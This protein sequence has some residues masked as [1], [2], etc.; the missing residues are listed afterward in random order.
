MTSPAQPMG[1]FDLCGPLPGPGVT[2]LEASAGTGKTFTIAGL[3]TR[4]VAEDVVPLSQILVVTFTRMATGELRDRVRTGLATAELALERLMSSGEAP[5]EDDDVLALLAAD[6]ASVPDRRRRLADAL[7]DFDSATI[8]TTHGF[9]H[10]VLAALGVWGEVAP[11]ASLLEDPTDLV[12]EVVDDL[13]A[14]HMLISGDLPF[15]RR[16]AVGAGK[17]AVFNPGTALAPRADRSDNTTSG[18]RRRLAEGTRRE[19]SRRL[20]DANLLTYDDLLVRLEKA[21]SDP[22]RGATAC[23]RLR[24]RYRAV[25]VDEFQDTDLVQ[26]EIVRRAFASDSPGCVGGHGNGD[27]DGPPE[28]EGD[29]TATRLVLIG[30]PKQ[31]VYSFRGA[32]VH[33]YLA[34]ARAAPAG[35]RSTLDENWRSDAG[36]LKAYDA[37]LSP[38]HLGHPGIEYRP[39]RAAPAHRLP[40]LSGAPVAAPLRARLVSRSGR[41]LH[42]TRSGLVQKDAALKWVAEDLASDVVE[43]LSSGAELLRGGSGQATPEPGSALWPRPVGPQDIGVLV[44]TNRQA[45]VVQTALRAAGVPVVVAGAQSVLSTPAARDWATLLNALEQPA[46]R[47][48]AVA[49]GL[50]AFLGMTGDQLATADDREWEALHAKLH[51]WGALARRSGV[52]TMFAN[53]SVS[54]RLPERLL[55][56]ADGE[57]RLTDLTHIAELLHAE[58]MSGQLGLAA[59][60]AWLAR[61]TGE[62]SPE[63]G[64]EEQRSRRLDS[65]AAAVQVLTVHRAKGL[66]FPVVYCPYL[67][68]GAARDRFGQPVVFHD[69]SGDEERKLDVGGEKGDCT[70]QSHFAA[71]Q[72]EKR[73]EDL[74]HLYVALTRAK[75]Q[76]VLWWAPARSCQHSALGRLLLSKDAEGDVAANGRPGE[77]K[78]PE[79]AAAFERV[80]RRAPGLVSVER[81]L[82]GTG[83]LWCPQPPAVTAEALEAARFER[84]LDA[85]W[86]R[87]SYTSITAGA[88]TYQGPAEL[89]SSEPEEPGTTDEPLAA[90]LVAGER[91]PDGGEVLAAGGEEER[92]LRSVPSLLSSVP[93]GAATG[94]FVHAVLERADFAAPDLRS[95]LEDAVQVLL[96]RYPGQVEGLDGLV[97]GLEAAITTPL[98]SLV[99]GARLADICRADR[100]DELSF[101]LTLAGGDEPHGGVVVSELAALFTR[102]SPPGAPLAPYGQT[103]AGAAV[104]PTLRGYLTGSLDMVFRRRWPNGSMKYFVVDYKTNWLSPPGEALTAWHYR[105]TVL[106]REMCRAHY[107]LQ[108]LFYLVALHRYL[109][110]RLPGY[111]P[112]ANLGGCLYLFVRG[113]LGPAAPPTSAGPCGV[114]TWRPPV[115]LV[116]D[117]S[118]LLNGTAR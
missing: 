61:R 3:V 8:T 37:L 53:A 111:D 39:A 13:F 50:T 85:G 64:E 93:P 115:A 104:P 101:E 71:C 80:A 9:C 68:D 15:R 110:W 118:N 75:H 2:L 6:R 95:N 54:E 28:R 107:P 109:R 23:A 78:D 62:E 21:L 51:E 40:G 24:H 59:L 76:T 69:A 84:V 55:S 26:W 66:E 5:P 45:T 97:A 112:A 106:G 82:G 83:Q 117:A 87:F 43:L 36:L 88:H 99:S 60:R 12:E 16:D 52:A 92:A 94:T 42:H 38:L 114:F 96:P 48:L 108:A 4:L 98:G 14:R 1:R 90:A 79:V 20:L 29:G 47:P 7:A 44:R 100:L 103:L 58:A 73:G 19:V 63:S 41:R 33:A 70:Y 17:E 10:M 74:R 11:G 105:P 65:D 30:D 102:H 77:P 81:A 86:R 67:W 34:A 18:L 113:M 89:V 57:R 72:A 25:L 32:D 116:E 49:T 56:E 35:Q 31:A 46:S 91:L 27:G 22:V